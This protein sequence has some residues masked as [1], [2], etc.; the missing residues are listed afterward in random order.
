MEVDVP[1]DL[2]FEVSTGVTNF[3]DFVNGRIITPRENIDITLDFRNNGLYTGEGN[4][5]HVDGY[6][7]NTGDLDFRFPIGDDFRLRTMTVLPLDTSFTL[8]KGAYFFENPNSPSTLSGFFNTNL[9]QNTLSI[10]STKEYWD[11]NGILPARVTLTWDEQS[12][13]SFLADEL[14]SLRVVGF[15]TALN[16]WVNLGNSAF[17]GTMEAGEITSDI[18]EPNLYSALTFGSVLRGNGA[19]TVYTLISPN[20][21]GKNDTL[22]IEGL[23]TSPDNELILFNRWG[24]EVF[25]KKNYDNS[26]NGISNGR[27]TLDGSSELPVGTYFYVLK[28][29]DQKDLAGAFYINR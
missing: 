6:V 3:F 16:Q 22:I 18:I 25:R 4:N 13:I 9:F 10:I 5:T 8:Y 20:G 17:S 27:V 12:D 1:N 2:F 28:L 21:D 26:F 15:S 11:L 7:N 19:I 14:S 29:Q 24:V 23:E